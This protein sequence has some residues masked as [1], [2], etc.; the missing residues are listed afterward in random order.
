M[1]VGSVPEHPGHGPGGGRGRADRA[2]ASSRS[3]ASPA[4]PCPGVYAAGD[5]TG[6]LMLASVAAMQGP[7]RDVA[8]AGGGGGPAAPEDRVGQRLHRP[9]GRLR[10]RDADPGRV[11]RVAAQTVTLPLATNARAEDAGR[12]RRLREVLL[13]ARLRH[14]A[15]RRGGRPRTPASWSC[16]SR[17][18][19]R[20]A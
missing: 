20:T 10:R 12:H 6:V 9:A 18:R 1:T 14:G 17:S 11:R 2:G 16:R 3:T 19:C 4:P 7:H 8:R 5:C 13:P 15:G